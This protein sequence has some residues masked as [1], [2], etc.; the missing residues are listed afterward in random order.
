MFNRDRV[1]IVDFEKELKRRQRKENISKAWN[2]F[3][4][5]VRNNQDVLLFV[6][7][8]AVTVISGATRI[9]SKLIARSTVEREIRFK[10]RTIYDHSLKRYAELKR[11]L[12]ASEAIEI[13]RRRNN[14][15]KLNTILNDMNL[16]KR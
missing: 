4:G 7:P 6:V 13:E 14:G 2:E 5:F 11:P 8:S 10:E 3:T 12:K 15:E 9:V 1:E 16:L